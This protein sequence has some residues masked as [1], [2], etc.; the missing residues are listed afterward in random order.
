M[1]AIESGIPMI[2]RSRNTEIEIA[3]KKLG[4]G[5]SFVIPLDKRSG[6]GRCAIR[7]GIKTATRTI[8]ANLVRV[9]R[10]E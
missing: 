4:I 9:W 2:P 1:I 6:I 8:G 7:C 3:M 5:D 10:L